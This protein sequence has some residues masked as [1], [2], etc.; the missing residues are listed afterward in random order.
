MNERYGA[1][2]INA[3]ATPSAGVWR[4]S[5]RISLWGNKESPVIA[6]TWGQDFATEADALAFAISAA[7]ERV[8][9]GV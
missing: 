9:S 2:N 4:A 8:D 5:A 1:H 3:I 6:L 7:K